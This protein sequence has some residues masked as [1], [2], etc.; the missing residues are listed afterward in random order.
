MH[1][2]TGIQHILYCTAGFATLSTLHE[3]K[4]K[5][6]QHEAQNFDVMADA[7]HAV[8]YSN[9]PIGVQRESSYANAA[10]PA[11]GQIDNIGKGLLPTP[12]VV[13]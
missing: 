8:L 5:L 6:L 3:L 2:W 13:G 7:T 4:A 12:S 1:P 9:V 11:K 10:G